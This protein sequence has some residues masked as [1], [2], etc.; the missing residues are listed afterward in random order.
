MRRKLKRPTGEAAVEKH[1]TLDSITS[2][3]CTGPAQ[4]ALPFGNIIGHL[5]LRDLSAEHIFKA[6]E[7][8]IRTG[9]SNFIS[10]P[11]PCVAYCGGLFLVQLDHN[12]RL[13]AVLLLR[14]LQTLKSRDPSITQQEILFQLRN[15]PAIRKI[16]IPILLFRA[17]KF[18]HTFLHNNFKTCH[19]L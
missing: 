19:C 16:D 4:R 14:F 13:P 10:N 3:F 5:F 12:H 8:A 18:T 17:S 9:V 6:L 2:V 15:V 11:I 1:Y 7:V